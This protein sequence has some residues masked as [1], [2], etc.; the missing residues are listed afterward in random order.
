M[1]T[2]EPLGSL[3]PAVTRSGRC[4]AEV[5]FAPLGVLEANACSPPRTGREH[6][7]GE[8]GRPGRLDVEVQAVGPP[9]EV[10]LCTRSL[11][12]S[13]T[14]IGEVKSMPRSGET[15]TRAR[16]TARRFP[17]TAWWRNEGGGITWMS[18]LM[19]SARSG[20]CRVISSNVAESIG[21]AAGSATMPQGYAAHHSVPRGSKARS[22]PSLVTRGTPW[23]RADA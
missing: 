15:S 22:A 23:T 10:G 4:W 20:H 18:P 6:L 7:D 14:S 2:N 13:S 17:T 1:T 11:S 5:E 21:G 8:V 19:S 12:L 3:H 16:R 9:R